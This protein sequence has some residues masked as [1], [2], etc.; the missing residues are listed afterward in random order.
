MKK[1]ISE[2]ERSGGETSAGHT[3]LW[4][5]LCAMLVA[6]STFLPYLIAYFTTP[7]GLQFQGILVLPQDLFG[8]LTKMKLGADGEW[9]FRLAYTSEDH[10]GALLS[11][12]YIALGRLS[13]AA[14]LPLILTFHLARLLT[15]VFLLVAVFYTGLTIF[16]R[17]DL[18]WAAFALVSF[19]SGL[20]WLLTP[21]GHLSSDLLIPES[22]TYYTI[23]D[24][25]HFPLAVGLLLLTFLAMLKAIER[26]NAGY[27]LIAGLL[28]L[29]Q[30]FI[31]PFLVITACTVSACWIG[32][33]NRRST[34]SQHFAVRSPSAW[35]EK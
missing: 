6:G 5:V 29:I 22:V 16:A 2:M 28:T 35:Q 11:I 21:F 31:Q 20:G 8:Y 33:A 9:L 19:A 24:N 18:A 3:L 17:K 23:L 26:R 30:T 10:Q 32:S 15:S 12:F 25:P 4:V 13:T 27:A 34:R 7:S 14:G 1:P